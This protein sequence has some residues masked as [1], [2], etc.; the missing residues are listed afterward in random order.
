[1]G[2]NAERRRPF[3]GIV[4]QFSQTSHPKPL[5]KAVQALFDLGFWV[6]AE[7]GARFRDVGKGLRNVAWLWRLAIDDGV[8][9]EF[10][11]EE[12]NQFVELNRA[13]LAE[14]ED[15]VVAL[16]VMDRSHDAV[17]DVVDVG[18]ITAR[19]AVAEDGDWFTLR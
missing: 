19:C 13:R 3:A 11:F 15:F 9:V 2:Q 4:E 1:M 6:V 10:L 17:D 14:I 5:D 8:R 12:R 16:V 18:V 7:Q